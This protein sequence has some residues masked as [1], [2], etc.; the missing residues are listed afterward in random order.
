LHN[1]TKV[2]RYIG[3]RYPGRDLDLS[4]ISSLWARWVCS[5]LF[6]LSSAGLLGL[7]LMT[8]CGRA[9]KVS[10]STS[11]SGEWHEFE[12]TWT[13]VGARTIMKLGGDRQAAVSTLN[14]SLVLAGPSRPAAG[15]RSEA[16]VFHDSATG[17]IGRAVWTNER[18]DKAY[19]ELRGEGAAANNKVMGTFVGGTGRYAG[20]TGDYEF[21]WRFM[22]ENED[23]T[24]QGQSVGLKGRVRVDAQKAGST[25][26]GNQ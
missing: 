3:V 14:G 17:L 19:S 11:P 24:V 1:K 23:G 8:A 26:G 5:S 25:G 13:A 16:I 18:G 21:S 6:A 2:G 7:V 12:G 4:S 9:P 22:L 15:F 20:V 10:A